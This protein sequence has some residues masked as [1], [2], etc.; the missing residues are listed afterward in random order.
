MK[1]RDEVPT[2]AAQ[3]GWINAALLVA[4]IEKAG[5][6]FTQ[7]SVIDAINAMTDFRADGI[8]PG[9][10][11]VAGGHGPGREQCTAFVEV[12]RGRFELRFASPAQ[13]FVCF[14]DN[15]VPG[16]LDAPSFKPAS[17]RP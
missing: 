5:R 3:A 17:A 2:P 15:P 14:P 12:V 11:W 7:E 16:R 13:P 9:L 6:G 8:L 1:Q 4:G 10:S